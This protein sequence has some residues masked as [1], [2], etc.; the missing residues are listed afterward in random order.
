MKVKLKRDRLTGILL[1]VMLVS[2]MSV[3]AQRIR[4]QGHI[5]NPQGKS[6]PNVNVL[7]PANDERIEMSDEDGRYSVLV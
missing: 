6:V 4:V 5:T 1:I 2:C 3:S 7:N